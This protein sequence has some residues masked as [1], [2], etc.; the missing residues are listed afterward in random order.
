MFGEQLSDSGAGQPLSLAGGEQRLLRLASTFF[1]PLAQ[2]RDG[3]AGEAGGASFPSFPEDLEV[4][5]GAEVDVAD[6]QRDELG[7][8]HAGLDC[9]QQQRV[10]APAEPGGPVRHFEAEL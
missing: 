2:D 9:C 10:V 6:V 3:L 4:S 8:A 5:A 1:E 7:D